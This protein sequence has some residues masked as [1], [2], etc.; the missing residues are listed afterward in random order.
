MKRISRRG[1]AIW[2]LILLLLAGTALFV[3]EFAAKAEQWAMYPGNPHIYETGK[4]T[5]AKG[6]VLDRDGNLLLQFGQERTYSGISAVRQ[7][8]MHW[9]GDRQG[10]VYAPMLQTYAEKMT[11]YDPISGAYDYS[12]QGGQAVLT[13]S[14]QVQQVALEAMGDHKGT[15]AVYNYKT[16]EILCA[17]TTPT[18]DP[19]AVPDITEDETGKYDGVYVNRFTQ[20]LFIPGSIF[21]IATTAAALEA[22]KDIQ[23]HTFT[24][25]GIEEYGIDKV[26]CVEAHGTMDLKRAMLLSCNCAYAQLAQLLGADTLEQYIEKFGVLDQVRFDGVTSAQGHV[27]LENAAAVELAWTAIGQH[28]DQINP[29]SYLAFVGAVANGGQGV[30]PY[31]VQS[32]TAGGKVTYEAQTQ[33]SQ[34]IMSQETAKVLQDYMRN[35]VELYYG[36]ENFPG[37]RVCAKSGTAE[38]GPELTPNAMF[39]GFVLDADYP[40]AFIVAIENG[41]YGQTTCMPILSKVL[42]A[43]MDALDRS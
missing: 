20:S 23:T 17:V 10:Y 42:P 30:Q 11:V 25:T 31:M 26:T 4:T 1:W 16:G 29:C 35:N 8:T 13:L 19:D 18:Y 38:V 21:K 41:G 32:V 2:L 15:I 7:S 39:T 36:D 43:C 3:A 12:G 22:L 37:L 40:L 5:P 27:D 6:S 9:L 24:C 34:R 33:L 14:S 28:E